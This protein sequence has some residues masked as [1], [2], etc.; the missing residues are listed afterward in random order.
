MRFVLVG[1]LASLF[2]FAA[3]TAPAAQVQVET[4]EEDVEVVVGTC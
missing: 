2:A 1:V 3:Q 4:P